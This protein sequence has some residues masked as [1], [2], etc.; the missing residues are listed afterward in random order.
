[1]KLQ[2]ATQSNVYL[3]LLRK[4]FLTEGMQMSILS[5]MG[6]GKSN[7]LAVLAEAAHGEQIPF[8]YY[9]P[10][11]D[12]ASLRELGDDVIVVGNPAD[13]GL[14]KPHYSLNDM[15]FSPKDFM[16][17][18]LKEGFS[19]VVSLA[20]MDL[21]GQAEVF[22]V[23]AEAQFFVAGQH[24]RPHLTIVDEAHRF[25]PQSPKGT[26]K[27]S[28]AQMVAFSSDGRKRGIMQAICTQRSTYLN[29]DC[30]F[31]SNIRLFG[32][33]TYKPDY[34]NIREYL[35]QDVTFKDLV[36]LNSGEFYMI[37][38]DQCQKFR[39]RLRTTTDLGGTPVLTEVKKLPRPSLKQLEMLIPA[40]EEIQWK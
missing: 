38:T 10:N 15:L 22:A 13:E 2:I 21:Q 11:G 1:M 7:G 8:V 34:Q 36:N 17:L 6:G 9:D 24:R 37:T 28:L 26:Q 27:E 32:K 31:A 3:D 4:P 14:R 30:L 39:F 25:A 35:P 23:L 12:A 29:K 33:T 19:M 40:Q 18:V 20:G 16:E 5:N